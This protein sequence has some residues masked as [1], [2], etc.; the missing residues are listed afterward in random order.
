MTATRPDD[1]T[2]ARVLGVDVATG[3]VEAPRP[4]AERHRRARVLVRV[5]GDPVGVVDVEA[6][7]DADVLARTRE[8]AWDALGTEL[9]R[10]ARQRGLPVPTGPQELHLGAS[11]VPVAPGADGGPLVT[12]AIASLRTVGPTLEC[13]RHVLASTHTRLEVV[14]VD[15]DSDPEPLRT[16]VEDAFGDDPRVRHAHEPRTGLSHARNKGVAEARGSIVVLTDDDVRVDPRW[17]ERIVAAFDAAP[18]VGCVTGSIMPAELETRAQ[19][20]LEEYGGFNK[21]FSQEV[22]DLGAHRRPEPLYPYDAGRFGSGANIAFRT[23]VVRALGGFAVDLGAGTPAH[24]GEDLDVLRRVVAAGHTLV[25][26]PSALLWHAHRRSDEALRRQ[27]YRYG[28]GLSATVTKWLLEDRRTAWD[29]LRRL[30]AGLVHVLAPSSPK[31]AGKSRAYPP[32]LTAL[33]LLGVAV[34]PVA[35]LRS[36]RRARALLTAHT[37]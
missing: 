35:Y 2:P 32:V 8:A 19:A 31:N 24:G 29:V 10:H 33:E 15:N 26:E 37:R 18:G 34:G 1:F 25:Y 14:V 21:G 4:G 36:R 22:F 6:G 7:D 11:G 20:W 9:V 16:A 3:A 28:V 13:V 30:P 17:L 5:C 23:E 27:M 12:V